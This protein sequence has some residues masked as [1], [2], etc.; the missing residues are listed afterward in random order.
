M[1]ET[2]VWS[3]GRED[4]LEKEMAT[5]SSTLAWRIPWKKEPGGL[6]SMGSQ[7]V[8]HDLANS[9]HFTYF[10]NKGPSSQGYGFSSSHVWMW[11]LDYKVSWAPKNRC[12]WTVVLDNTLENPLESKEI[13]P[14][15]PKGDQLNIHWKD[16]CW[17]WNSNTLATWCEELTH[18][19]SPWCWDWG[20]EEKGTTEDKMV[21]WLHRL[22]GHG[23][24]WT[25]GVGDG[26]GSLV[27]C[28]PWGQKVWHDWVTELNCLTYKHISNLQFHDTKNLY[29]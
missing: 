4:L 29:F 27:C 12:F 20:Q 21:G 25:P 8:R 10:A 2:R 15:H 17:S 7:R 16:W 18:L 3:L 22:N 6:Q 28:S 9:L 11:G 23:F 26:Q 13:Q 14:V 1:Q 24:G 5:H 19:K